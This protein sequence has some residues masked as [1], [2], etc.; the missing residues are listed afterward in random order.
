MVKP[1]WEFSMTMEAQLSGNSMAFL[2]CLV[3]IVEWTR[4]IR[5]YLR[6]MGKRHLVP[7]P[8]GGFPTPRCNLNDNPIFESADQKLISEYP[9]VET[10][11]LP[12]LSQSI[13]NL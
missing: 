1:W 7:A 13:P 6:A 9:A 12:F 11:L 8:E 4:M 5:C 2:E 10:P 3:L